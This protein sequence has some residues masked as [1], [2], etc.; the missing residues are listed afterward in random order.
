MRVHAPDI[1]Q[2]T[3]AGQFVHVRC[4]PPTGF[5]PLLRRPIS[6]Y[7]LDGDEVLLYYD[8]VGRG[9]G[10]LA[11]RRPGDLLDVLGPL[12]KPFQV[13]SASRR[14]LM[15]GG[16]IGLAPLV[17]LA[18]QLHDGPVEIVLLGG[19]RTAGRVLPPGFV[20]ES[21]EYLVATEDGSSGQAGYVTDL[22][23]RYLDWADQVFACGPTR[24][25]QAL[26]PV[27]APRATLQVTVSL[28]ERMACG[29]GVC[30]SCVVQTRRGVKRVCRDGPVFDLSDLRA[31]QWRR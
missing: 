15:V 22:V 19:F 8:V 11:E 6:I 3:R 1:A 28:E 12:G 21:A 10:F 26:H 18:R 20:P 31:L 25:M 5:D 17:A 30:L 27:V 2:D 9:T 4:G 7:G 13:D 23:P 29:M 24:M 14:L 16:G